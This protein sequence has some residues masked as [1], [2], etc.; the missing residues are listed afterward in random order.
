MVDALQGDGIAF[1]RLELPF[2]VEGN[3]LTVQDA[4]ASGFAVGVNAEGT[5]DLETD[6]VDMSGTI[7]PAY[8]LNTLVDKIPV[9]GELLTGGKGQGLFAAS[10]RVDGTTEEPDIAVNPL[11]VLTPGFLRGLFSFMEEGE[12]EPE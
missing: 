3:V 11:T 4:R 7:V 10:Y 1:S 2:S 9:L 5:V 6:E 8:S 12:A